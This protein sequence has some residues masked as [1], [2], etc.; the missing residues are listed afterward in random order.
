[1]FPASAEVI[2][3]PIISD[4]VRDTKAARV[5]NESGWHRVG[6]YVW[7]TSCIGEYCYMHVRIVYSTS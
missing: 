6:A 2:E 3:L 1:M 7:F 4:R 5:P